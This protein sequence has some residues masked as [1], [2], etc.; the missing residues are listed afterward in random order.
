MKTKIPHFNILPLVDLVLILLVFFF[1]TVS[2][3]SFSQSSLIQ[4]PKLLNGQKESLPSLL[5]INQQNQLIWKGKT[6][7]LA[8]LKS[9]PLKVVRIQGDR[10]AS[11]E[12]T[13]QVLEQLQKQ[14]VQS[15]SFETVSP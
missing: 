5:M 8:E 2:Q 15:V 11:L 4:L 13:V 10:R 6:L 1:Y 9:L 3:M 7:T 12:I 14:G